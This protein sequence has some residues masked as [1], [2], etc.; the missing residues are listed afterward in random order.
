[1]SNIPA[2]NARNLRPVA[3]VMTT[4]ALIGLGSAASIAPAATSRTLAAWNVSASAPVRP[5]EAGTCEALAGL[6]LDKVVIVTAAI[7][8]G[9][10][11]V[12]LKTFFGTP[13]GHVPSFCRVTARLHPTNDSDIGIE[14]WLPVKGWDGR[15]HGVGVGGFA[16]TFDYESL[17]SAVRAGQVGFNSDM[18][19]KGKGEGGGALIDSSW[20]K[21]HPEKVRDYGS[22]AVHVGTVTA[23]RI[24]KAFYGRDVE[25][26]YFVGCSGG[27]RQGLM[28][29]AR[30]PEDY[31][32][33]MAGAPAASWTGL[34][35]AMTNAAQAQM[36]PGAG[37][38]P[39]QMAFL[40]KEV[41]RQCDPVDGQADG[42]VSDPL[43]CNFKTTELACERNT[44]AG[45]FS[46]AQIGALDRIYKGPRTRSGSLVVPTY[47]PAGAEDGF[48]GWP[49]YV[50]MGASGVSGGGQHTDG[51]Y[52]NVVAKPFTTTATFDFDKDPARLRAALSRELDAPANLRRFFGR[53]GKLLIWHGWGDAAI[54]PEASLQF[55]AAI[56]Q[57]SGPKAAD[58]TRLF[59]VPG[60]QH[61]AGG[62]GV[63]SFGQFGAPMPSASPSHNVVAALQQWVER[64]HAPQELVGTLGGMNYYGGNSENPRKRLLCALPMRAILRQGTDPDKAEN[65][66]CSAHE[67]IR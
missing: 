50:A 43:R 4:C 12:T 17:A 59:M 9:D 64:G 15:F 41:T 25:Y 24:V 42:L 10:A 8:G 46:Q 28:E 13:V 3:G 18:G 61:C 1:M 52:Q 11:S 26:A 48:F 47:L 53:G 33:V 56:L 66:S 35:M 20:A 34:A 16:G 19:H 45:C 21:G 51:L 32:G 55:R 27:G 63:N 60:L 37:L 36:E 40:Q 31:D 5:V 2:R 58:A 65:Y 62:A 54:A 14:V 39:T 6:K 67:K 29:A 49:A 57:Q 7:E 30:Y 23:K 22:R 44:Q 38:L